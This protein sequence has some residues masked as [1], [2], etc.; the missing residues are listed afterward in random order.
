ML[1]QSL[2]ELPEYARQ[3]IARVFD[4]FGHAH[5]DIGN[6]LRQDETVFTQQ[7]TNLVSLRGA[8]DS[9]KQHGRSATTVLAGQ[10]G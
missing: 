7:A 4:E 10:R 9:V 6:A 8:L 5:G 1:K 3:L 2:D